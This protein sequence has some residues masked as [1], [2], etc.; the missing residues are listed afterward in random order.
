MYNTLRADPIIAHKYQIWNFFY[1]SGKRIGLSAQELREAL[2]KI[3]QEKDPKGANTALHRMV[4]IGHSQGGLV[5]KM[6]ATDTGDAFVRMATGKSLAELKVSDEVRANIEKE[7]VFKALPF[8]SRVVFISTPHRGS[9]L[10]KN[11]VR[12]LVLKI[13]KLPQS[14]LHSTANLMTTLAHAGVSDAQ[15]QPFVNM[16]SLDVM[17]PNSPILKTL[18]DLPL[19]SGIKGHSIVAIDG[20]DT[21]PEGDD[22][23]VKYTSA[24]VD[25]VASEFLVRNGHSC[26]S[27]PLVIEEVRRI[28]L[29]HLKEN[30]QLPKQLPDKVR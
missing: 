27:H 30:Q 11:W 2:N 12:T 3:V 21:P 15:A 19:A 25:Y 29:E 9:F 17:S 10:S 22:G 23:V 24:H 13:V 4:V 7:A 1:D 26:Q 14:V 5:T 28:L 16:T 20:N 6:V 8:V 18:A